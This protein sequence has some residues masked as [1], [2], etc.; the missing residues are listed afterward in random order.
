MS[1]TLEKAL[2]QWLRVCED[3]DAMVVD[4]VLPVV[5]PDM[6]LLILWQSAYTILRSNYY[7]ITKQ[8]LHKC[9]ILNECIKVN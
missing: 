6:L 2:S 9:Q 8:T 7:E 1:R 4:P 5:Q 3:S